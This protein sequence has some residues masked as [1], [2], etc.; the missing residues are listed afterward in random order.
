MVSRN[1]GIGLGGYMSSY[2][3]DD[4]TLQKL[5]E[6]A[7]QDYKSYEEDQN[8]KDNIS[9][10]VNPIEAFMGGFGLDIPG[11]VGAENY[12]SLIHI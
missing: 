5:R 1:S 3:Y 12:L 2:G 4:E 7:E 10:I 6:E 11:M 8:K 9:K